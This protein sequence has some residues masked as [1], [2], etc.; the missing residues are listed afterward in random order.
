ML[1]PVANGQRQV[2][3]D[4][5]VPKTKSKPDRVDSET[6]IPG[7][8]LGSSSSV[9]GMTEAHKKLFRNR[10]HLNDI[11]IDDWQIKWN[12]KLRTG[13]NLRYRVHG[14]EL[15]RY[16]PQIVKVHGNGGDIPVLLW[17]GS[18]V[19]EQQGGKNRSRGKK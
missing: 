10:N 15:Q 1:G 16:C 8:V 9:L 5:S 6:Y 3:R 11:L 12:K 17:I 18:D 14:V 13:P 4:R 7:L 2:K 19:V